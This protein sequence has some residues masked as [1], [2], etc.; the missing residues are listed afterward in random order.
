MRNGRNPKSPAFQFYPGDFLADRNVAAMTMEERGVYV[1]LLCFQW[2]DGPLPSDTNRLARMVH[3]AP[4]AFARLWESLTPCF[5]VVTGTT[6][7][8][9]RLERERGFQ[10]E[11]RSKRL[12]ASRIAQEARL[13]L[14]SSSNRARTEHDSSPPLHP[15]PYAP[16]PTPQALPPTP[17]T[18]SPTRN[19]RAARAVSDA[20]PIE[21]PSSLDS[22]EFR[23][24]LTD[25]QAART[26]QRIKKLGPVGLKN[27]LKRLAEMGPQRA[28]AALEFSGGF[29]GSV[30]EPPSKNGSGN[31][32]KKPEPPV[33]VYRD[34]ADLMREA[35]AKRAGL[36][37]AQ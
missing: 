20:A 26:E 9:G 7:A 18:L 27:L 17:E 31:L 4:E 24:A 28:I 33:P 10:A 29:K 36:K 8:N 5:D 32:F 3:I 35:E 14:E 30:V 19:P 25:Y 23:T 6:I 16:S 13:R 37:A 11:G 15:T 22:P 21:I 34:A 2:I 1:T 12:E